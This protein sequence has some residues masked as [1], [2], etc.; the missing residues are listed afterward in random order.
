MSDVLPQV[1]WTCN[2]LEAQGYSINDNVLYQDN[3]SAIL[4]EGN[5]RMSSSKRTRHINIRY[6]F[7]TNQ[8]KKGEMRV[9]LPNGR[10]G[11]RFHYQTS[12]GGAV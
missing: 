6:F 3:K 5:R 11:G 12:I 1:V 10:N 4:L 8:I 7:V 2:F 9:E